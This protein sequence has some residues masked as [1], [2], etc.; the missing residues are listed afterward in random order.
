MR[1]VR[2]A[3]AVLLLL[4]TTGCISSTTLIRLNADGSGTIEHTILLSAAMVEQLTQMMTGMAEAFGGEDQK[5]EKMELFGESELRDKAADFGQGVTFVS[6][7]PIKTETAE[8]ARVVYAFEDVTQ[9][10]VSQKPSPPGPAGAGGMPVAASEGERND[11]HFRFEQAANGH[12]ILT[13][14]AP[15][16]E[17]TPDAEEAASE[18][19]PEPPGEKPG[20]EQLAQMRK[21][22][23]GFKIAIAVEVAGELVRTTCPY[24]DGNRVTLLEMD[25]AQLLEDPEKLALMAGAGPQIDSLEEAQK[26]LKGVPGI[27]II[28]DPETTIEFTGR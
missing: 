3:A 15:E 16:P 14:V 9:L 25:F 5:A 27:K 23:E 12:S 4:A 28:L 10:H 17:A 7:E 26:L 24:V 8:G 22:F 11:L 2:L 18:P 21:M 1:T 13:V 20:P 19:A 6:N